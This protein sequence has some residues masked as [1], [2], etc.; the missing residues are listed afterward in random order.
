MKIID[1]FPFYNELELLKYRLQVLYDY[2]DYFV[3]VESTHTYAGHPTKLYYEENKHM[4]EPFASKIIHVIVND[5]P[6][7]YPNINYNSGQ[8]WENEVHPRNCITRGLS[9]IELNENDIIISTD[10]DEICNPTVLTKIRNETLTLNR[11]IYY[12]LEQDLYYYNLNSKFS[13]TWK[14]SKIF[15]YGYFI[16]SSRTLSDIRT[17][18][19][20]HSHNVITCGGWHLSYFGD[21]YFIQNKIQQFAHQEFNNDNCTNINNIEKRMNAQSDVYGR[22]YEILKIPINEN[23]NLP[24]R[25]RELLSKYILY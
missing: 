18:H 13:E 11:D 5:M 24:P 3:L 12:I 7:I 19:G 9:Q 25:C 17:S 15:T 22:N 20:V 10:L 21:K 4:F 8:Q 6:Y 16:N 1:C 23:T 14:H 2:V